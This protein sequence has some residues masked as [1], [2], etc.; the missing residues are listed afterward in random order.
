MDYKYLSEIFIIGDVII[1]CI[2]DENNLGFKKG[3]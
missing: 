1:N 2:V 3:I